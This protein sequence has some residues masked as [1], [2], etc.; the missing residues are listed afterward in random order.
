MA[1]LVVAWTKELEEDNEP[2]DEPS[3]PAAPDEAYFLRVWGAP[4]LCATTTSDCISNDNM[5]HHVSL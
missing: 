3:E 4:H 2:T 5:H 1:S